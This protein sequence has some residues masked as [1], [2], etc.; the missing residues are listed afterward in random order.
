MSTPDRAKKPAI[1]RQKARPLLASRGLQVVQVAICAAIFAHTPTN[2][3]WTS[4]A[5]RETDTNLGPPPLKPLG[6]S[7]HYGIKQLTGKGFRETGIV[8]VIEVS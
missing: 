2:N 3:S 7:E 5:G 4:E 6:P 8:G 1:S